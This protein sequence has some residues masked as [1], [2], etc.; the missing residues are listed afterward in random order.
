M[1]LDALK[2]CNKKSLAQMAKERGISG[3]HAMRKDQLI[4][5]LSS[6][7]P[8]GGPRSRK[9][10]PAVVNA[11]RPQA[12][13]SKPAAA[14]KQSASIAEPAVAGRRPQATASAIPSQPHT[15][16]H[17]CQKDRIIVLA[18]D[19]YWLHAHWELSRTTLARAQA[20][21][22]QEWHSA[23]PILRVM[24]V[25]SEDTTTATER[26]LRDVPIHG[27][28][29]NWY[30]DVLAPPRSFRVDIGYLSRRGKFYV[31]A[32]SNIVT[33]PRAGVS[34]ALEE[35]WSD[36]QQQFDRVQNPSTIGSPRINTVLDLRELF[37]ERLRRPLCSGSMQ[38]LSIAGLPGL[39]RKF[40]FEIDAEL[41]VYGTTEPNARVTLQ[42]E[43]VHLRPDGS[44]TVR[45]SLPDS[46]Q[47]IPAVAS[48]PDGVE[49][50]TIVLAVERNTKELEPT[51]HDNNE[52]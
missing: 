20:A 47:I 50:R 4:R 42:G 11:T 29:N 26:H 38:N 32:R 30:L 16:D 25:T 8:A 14:R 2:D 22:G 28:V 31:L 43:P 13:R 3:W 33:T 52:L 51:I 21:L 23:Q 24:D 12:A 18:R 41:I 17:A 1:T 10:E 27:G 9:V 6:A 34:D 37:E 46:R 15:L 35:N 48:S 40:H 19:S 49:E 45:Y 39:G 7:R 5:A 36:V 44:F